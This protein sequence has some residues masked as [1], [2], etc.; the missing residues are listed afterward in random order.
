MKF[1]IALFMVVS[2]SAIAQTNFRTVM[3]DTNG[4]IQR[5]T[6]FWLANSNSINAIIGFNDRIFNRT[7]ATFA[8][9][10]NDSI[11]GTAT[12]SNSIITTTISGTNASGKAA[13]RLIRDVNS[14][15]AAGVGT[16][17]AN[18]S[19]TI[20]T[21]IDSLPSHGTVRVVLGNSI[22]STTNVAE[23]PTNRAIGFELSDAGGETNQVRLI[24]H[25]GTT[26]TNGPW[27]NIGNVFQRYW[28]GVEQN[29]T[30]GEVKLYVGLNSATPTNNTNA[31]IFG[32][33]TNNAG[34]LLSGFDVGVFTTNT[35]AQGA[36][37]S[38]YSAF[39]DVT[40]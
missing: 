4:V 31:T 21:R 13:V 36:F 8:D 19:H 6:N 24:A 27:V 14:R 33:P 28:I 25:N 15:G 30:N 10:L 32:G 16:I 29:K 5:P 37:F 26:N 17:F 18:D 3:S 35:N 9:L 39:V 1:L 11:N 7:T 12:I 38:V 34:N 22:A 40:D 23:Y 2:V 20:W